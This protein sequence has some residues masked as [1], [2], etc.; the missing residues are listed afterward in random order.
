[1]IGASLGCKPWDT[2]ACSQVRPATARHSDKC[3]QKQHGMSLQLSLTDLS[4]LLGQQHYPAHVC[5]V[6]QSLQEQQSQWS[7]PDPLLRSNMKD[8]LAEDF[9]PVYKVTAA[10]FN[11][12]PDQHAPERQT[13][14]AL[15]THRSSNAGEAQLQMMVLRAE[16]FSPVY[17]A[18]VAGVLH[19]YTYNCLTR[20]CKLV[21]QPWWSAIKA[22]SGEHDA[23]APHQKGLHGA[24]I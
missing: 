7:I 3:A 12:H 6:L 16:D 9:L 4:C 10:R 1:M 20:V 13:P 23:H 17:R 2:G 5:N 11:S 8:A 21:C 24:S 14:L 22:S 18:T 15:G 19:L